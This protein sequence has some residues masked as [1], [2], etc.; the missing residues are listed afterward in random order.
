MYLHGY[1]NPHIFEYDTLTSEDRWNDLFDVILANPPFMTP[2][3]G[4]KPH[5][6]FSIQSSRSEILFV[7]YIIEHLNPN[8]RAGVIVPIGALFGSTN[9][10]LQFRKLLLNNCK[11]EAVISLPAGVFQPYSGV[12]TAVLIFVKGGKTDKVWFYLMKN[13]GFSLDQKREFMDGQGDIP[14]MLRKFKNRE[15]SVNSFV[16]YYDELERHGFSLS[17]PTYKKN[18]IQDAYHESPNKILEQLM[19]TQNL[20]S[21]EL[22]NIQ[23]G[24]ISFNES[25]QNVSNT[26]EI[27]VLELKNVVSK[28][29]HS[30]KRGPFG[31]S[32]KKEIFVKEGFKVYEQQNAIKNNCYIGEYYV[33][34]EKY[35]EMQPFAVNSEDLIISCSGTIGK[36]AIIPKDAKLGIINQ[37]LLKITV[38]KEIILPKYMKYMLE[39][40]QIQEAMFGSARGSGIKNAAPME[41]IRK[42]KLVV[43]SIP[44]QKQF[45][46]IA[47]RIES[48]RKYQL[49]N[50]LNID[51][52]ISS[53]I[54]DVFSFKQHDAV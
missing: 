2:K 35:E 40:P 5:N 42:T 21:E 13:D 22:V 50:M 38:N 54:A 10:H 15:E 39:T 19:E 36:I 17:F 3:G 44:I 4:I 53:I 16:V 49:G 30:L 48:I 14:D 8:G 27:K 43:P 45:V 26:G 32:L 20:L 37:A 11:L 25:L 7:D 29:K 41:S 28:D 23:K 51:K 52:L 31:G 34:K 1:L 18:G 33:T 47:E 6:R 9:A 12:E 24:I 46:E